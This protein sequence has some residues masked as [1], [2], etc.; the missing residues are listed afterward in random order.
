MWWLIEL[1][2]KKKE[3]S[4][5]SLLVNQEIIE[6]KKSEAFIQ[7]SF[8]E[9]EAKQK[10]CGLSTSG[11]CVEECRHYKVGSVKETVDLNRNTMFMLFKPVCRLWSKKEEPVY[12]R[13][14]V[15]K[16]HQVIL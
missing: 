9:S 13:T 10:R 16:R 6:S 5:H 3:K 8:F 14:N 1:L 2:N 4:E 7:L 12:F 11:C 15:L